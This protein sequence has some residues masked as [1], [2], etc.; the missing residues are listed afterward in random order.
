MPDFDFALLPESYADLTTENVQRNRQLLRDLWK[1][2]DPTIDVDSGA[3][4]SLVVNPAATLLEVGLDAFR[5][6]RKSS[7]LTALLADSSDVSKMMLE[8]L[9][10]SYRVQRK[11]VFCLF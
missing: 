3:L 9:A 1:S 4:S 5:T 7:S 6:A 2:A 8:E 10:S 11:L